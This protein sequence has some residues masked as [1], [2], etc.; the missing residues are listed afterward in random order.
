[1]QGFLQA[2]G[3]RLKAAVLHHKQ[4][5]VLV[6][7]FSAPLLRKFGTVPPSIAGMQLVGCCKAGPM[8]LS[9]GSN[10]L[11]LSTYSVFRIFNTQYN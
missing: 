9:M 4:M 8:D 2:Q 10:F 7:G 3:P 5:P 6:L 11:I 1:M